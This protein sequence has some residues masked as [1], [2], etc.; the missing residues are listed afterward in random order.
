MGK[1]LPVYR[2]I[3]A[4]RAIAALL[5][6]CVHMGNANGIESRYISSVGPT[7]THPLSL[8]GAYGVDLFFVISGFIMT[9]TTWETFAKRGA[10]PRFLLRR[11]IRIY[12]PYWIIFSLLLALYLV[13][14]DLIDSH[15]TSRPDLVASFLLLPQRSEPLLLVSWTLVFEMAFYLV[16][17]AALC[18]Q[19]RRLPIVLAAW[20]IVIGLTATFFG[21]VDNP[22]VQFLASPL[23]IEFFC[24]IAVGALVVI[25]HRMPGAIAIAVGIALFAELARITQLAGTAPNDWLRV[26]LAGPAFAAI[27]YGSVLLEKGG[28]TYPRWLDGLG[29]ASYAMY[30]W[31]VPVL[32][33]LGL[34]TLRLHITNVGMHAVTVAAFFVAIAFAGRVIFRFIERPMTSALNRRA[35]LSRGAPVVSTPAPQSVL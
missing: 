15:A 8:V 5:V 32:T 34:I 14:P 30:L 3:Q 27:L 25:G 35:R 28:V 4:L 21:G 1:R 29:D 7:F 12:P 6:I 18:L 16:F 2:N 17:T 20:A 26:L 11:L 33:A 31:H 24:G 10:A 22:Y 13:R 9:V 23:P 19:R